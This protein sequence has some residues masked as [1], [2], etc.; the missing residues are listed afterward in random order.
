MNILVLCDYGQVR[1]VAM[2]ALLREQG[3]F[4][5]AGSYDNYD[6][7][8]IGYHF[9]SVEAKAEPIKGGNEIS[10]FDKVIFMQEGAQ[11]FIGRDTY[12]NFDH[13]ELRTK[14]WEL[15]SKLG[16]LKPHLQAKWRSN[17]ALNSIVNEFKEKEE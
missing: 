16:L 7:L 13:P 10:I 3:H 12:G 6:S 14:C 9:C 4:A 2:A 11:H 17:N 8:N 15:A 1:S 5:V